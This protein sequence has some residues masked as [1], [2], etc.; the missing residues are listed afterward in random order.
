MAETPDTKA[1][2]LERLAIDRRQ[3][4]VGSG[5]GRGM[6]LSVI[7]LVLLGAGLAGVWY[8]RTTGRNIIA[9]MTE[10]PIEVRL[11]TVAAIEA[12]APEIALA[13]TG[14]IVSDQR[15]NVATKVSGQIV[16]LHVE[17]GDRVEAGQ[18]LARI[19]DVFYRAA[20]DEAAAT[21]ARYRFEQADAQ[22]EV[23]RSNAA[24]LQDEALA[25]FQRR[26]YE[27]L[28][29]LFRTGQASEREYLDAK[30]LNDSAAATLS[31]AKA[32]VQASAAQVDVAQ[33]QLA[34]SEA[35]LRQFQKRLDDC[36][37]QAPITGVVLERNAEVGDFL[38]AEGG[39]G[40]Q[41]N[42][43]LVSVA[44]MTR[45]RVEVDVSERDIVRVFPRQRARIT[46]DS[47]K[48]RSYP[49]HVMWIDPIGDYAKATVQVKVRIEDPG[50][51]LRIE[52]SAKVEFERPAASQPASGKTRSVWLSK[53]A[54]A[55]T[56]GND[57]AVVYTVIENRAVANPVTVGARSD[58][59]VE[60]RIGVYGGMKIVADG[61]E[62]LRDG[63]LVVVRP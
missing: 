32:A 19:E 56:P 47:D 39:R 1:L 36:A 10:R 17:Q 57:Q 12:A 28:T 24:V 60:I 6:L 37:I 15:V 14:R 9:S 49:G 7:V 2:S 30:N 42:A 20:R 55:L 11:M 26:N 48:A 40:A 18:V 13:A 31:V 34:A 63:A 62:K 59:D 52:G 58:A 23:A 38:A 43:Q 44:D 51:D 16:E 27:R 35:A 45:L 46:P 5:G 3:R 21:V 33:S 61:V 29:A 53:N 8:Y 4:P 41:A 25:E 22:A 54:V 50:P